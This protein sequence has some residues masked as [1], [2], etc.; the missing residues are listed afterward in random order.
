MGKRNMA[1]V[2]EFREPIFAPRFPAAVPV[3]LIF[4]EDES[5]SRQLRL[6]KCPSTCVPD[7]CVKFV[8]DFWLTGGEME[9]LNV[10]SGP[11]PLTSVSSSSRQA[12]VRII[13]CCHN[14]QHGMIE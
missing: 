12:A 7:G 14:Y 1:K 11:I 2:L 6:L 10:F 3:H 9:A 13:N 4:C 5:P 8:I